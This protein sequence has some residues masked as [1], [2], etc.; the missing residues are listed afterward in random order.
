[1]RVEKESLYILLIVTTFY[2]KYFY[3][4]ETYFVVVGGLNYIGLLA[5][6]RASILKQI[7]CLGDVGNTGKG[8]RR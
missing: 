3:F 5:E 8:V 7:A 4:N 1:M 6:P 2:F